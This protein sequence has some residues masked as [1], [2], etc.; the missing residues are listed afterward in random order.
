MT[1]TFK[2]NSSMTEPLP[3]N[4]SNYYSH[5]TDFQYMSK[6]IFQ[7]FEKC[8]A[9]TL[10]EL[11]GEW[12]PK[13]L[14]K[15]SSGPDPLIFGNFIHSYFQG[16]EAHAEFL[17][18]KDTIEEVYCHNS[19]G[20]PISKLKKDYS[21]DGFA[22]S[23]INKMKLNNRFNFFYKPRDPENKEVIVTGQIGGYWWKGKIDSL[24]LEDRYFCDLKT[25][26]DIHAANWIKQGDRN[27]KTNFVEAYGYYMQMAIYRE[28]IRQTFDIDCIPLMFVV[29]KQQPIPEV[30]N[31][32][33]DESDPQNPDVKYLME[34]AL[35][36]AEELQPHYWK[37]LMGE[38]K[39]KRCGK[40][41]YCRYTNN[42]PEFILPT[43]IEV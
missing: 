13:K 36:T 35:K 23:L 17:K 8:E 11:K 38:E 1:T 4:Q 34:D 18:E 21:E 14:K 40:C 42:N 26:K 31:L 28:L 6:S 10:A 33:F 5:D 3:L 41:D 22:Y 29:S 12:D 20:E 25:T 9:E 32:I 39:P 43:Q 19:K 16:E 27:V 24:N 30:A 2:K 37:V 15:K 7:S